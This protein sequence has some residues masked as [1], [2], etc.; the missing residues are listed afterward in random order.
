MGIDN[1]SV[2]TKYTSDD[3]TNQVWNL[4]VKNGTHSWPTPSA[5]EIDTNSLIIEFFESIK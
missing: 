4:F 3:K 2:L 5:N 1:E